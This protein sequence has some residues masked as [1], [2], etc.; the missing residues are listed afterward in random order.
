M[1]KARHIMIRQVNWWWYLVPIVPILLVGYAA[2]M[3]WL[4]SWALLVALFAFF[5]WLFSLLFTLFATVMR[6]RN[7]PKEPRQ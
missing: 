7:P 1:A 2:L 3:S 6:K 5:M 4:P